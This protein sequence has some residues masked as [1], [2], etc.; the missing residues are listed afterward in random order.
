MSEKM[1]A[2]EGAGGK[3]GYSSKQLDNPPLWSPWNFQTRRRDW[4][5]VIYDE[6]RSSSMKD[7]NT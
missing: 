5:E 3:T 2:A 6:I 7:E 4:H 1:G